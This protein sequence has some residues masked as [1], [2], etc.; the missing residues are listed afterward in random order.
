MAPCGSGNGWQFPE[1][2]RQAPLRTSQLE[3]E[4]VSPGTRVKTRETPFVLCSIPFTTLITPIIIQCLEPGSETGLLVQNSVPGVEKADTG[5]P[6]AR[7]YLEPGHCTCDQQEGS[8]GAPS[9]AR[10]PSEPS[11][12]WENNS[13]LLQTG[14]P[15]TQQDLP[16][17]LHRF[18]SAC[19][20]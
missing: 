12:G 10:S 7:V 13:P 2:Q 14:S 9:A 8:P 11:W 5:T 15:T 4:T 3:D 6:S 19:G 18:S 20:T 17:K 1:P 16:K